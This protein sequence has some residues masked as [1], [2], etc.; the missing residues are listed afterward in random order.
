VHEVLQVILPEAYGQLAQQVLL[1][2]ITACPRD[3]AAKNFRKCEMLEERYKIGKGFVKGQRVRVGCVDVA[4]VNSIQNGVRCFVH[5][6]VV[7]EAREDDR[8]R[9]LQ[10]RA[11]WP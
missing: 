4:P 3:L 10:L 11:G 6:D 5:N 1:L 9:Q 2:Q 8:T 7:T